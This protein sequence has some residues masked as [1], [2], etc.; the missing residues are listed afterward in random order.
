MNTLPRFVSVVAV[1]LGCF[2]LIRGLVHTVLFGN[3]GAETAGLDLTGP[4]GRDQLMLMAAFGSANFITG[5]ALIYLGLANRLGALILMVVIPIALVTAGASVAYWGAD[6]VGQGVFPGTRNMQV[7]VA[8][9]VV[10]VIA[11]VL[12]RKSRGDRAPSYP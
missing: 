4:T 7:Y 12:V 11:G 2:D 8:V 5:A 9:C 10:T 1:A 6:L 3:V